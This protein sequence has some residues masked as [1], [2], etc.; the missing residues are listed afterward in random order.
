MLVEI[1]ETEAPPRKVASNLYEEVL[2]DDL[3]DSNL[4]STVYKSTNVKRCNLM[5][6]STQICHFVSLYRLWDHGVLIFYL[7]GNLDK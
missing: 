5:Q 3:N 2:K 6:G 1:L 7:S 4:F